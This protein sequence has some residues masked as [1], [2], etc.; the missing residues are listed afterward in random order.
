MSVRRQQHPQS[1]FEKD[2]CFAILYYSFS[3]SSSTQGGGRESKG[4]SSPEPELHGL[5]DRR[6][7][8]GHGPRRLSGHGPWGRLLRL[9]EPLP[10]RN[11]EDVSGKNRLLNWAKSSASV[12]RV[13]LDHARLPSLS[14]LLQFL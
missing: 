11:E 2:L 4:S 1:S 8:H 10:R 6:I 12:S 9:Q 14:S 7:L 5:P 3:T 13:L